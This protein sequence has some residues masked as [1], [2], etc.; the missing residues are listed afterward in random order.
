[1]LGESWCLQWDKWRK[2]EQFPD[3]IFFDNGDDPPFR[4]VI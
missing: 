3:E 2:D 4:E 1:M